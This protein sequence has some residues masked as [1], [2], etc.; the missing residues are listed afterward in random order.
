MADP[1]LKHIFETFLARL[2]VH[3]GVWDIKLNVFEFPV[4]LKWFQVIL[5][6]SLVFF[7]CFIPKKVVFYDVFWP[8]VFRSGCQSRQAISVKF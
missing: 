8:H 4:H 2:F 3:L 6:I 7:S 5:G 1:I